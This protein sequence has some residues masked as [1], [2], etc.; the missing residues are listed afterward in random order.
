VSVFD[1]IRRVAALM[2][3][4][5]VPKL[6]RLA[7][8]AAALYLLSPVDFVPELVAP[9]VGYLDDIVVV[10]MALRWLITRDPDRG[11][12]NPGGDLAR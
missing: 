3:D 4:P 7:V 11:A 10:W 2:A 6:P 8:I 5:R 9:V 12:P 1:R